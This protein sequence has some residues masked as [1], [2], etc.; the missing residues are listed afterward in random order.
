[1]TIYFPKVI[2][3]KWG[4]EAFKPFFLSPNLKIVSGFKTQLNLFIIF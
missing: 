1:M 2:E 3:L 4:L